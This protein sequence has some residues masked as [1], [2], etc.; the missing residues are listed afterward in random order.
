[1]SNLQVVSPNNKKKSIKYMNVIT[2]SKNTIYSI[3]YHPI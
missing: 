1:M 2:S 3:Y